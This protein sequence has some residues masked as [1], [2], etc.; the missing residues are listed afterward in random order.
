MFIT[1]II[2]VAEHGLV[3]IMMQQMQKEHKTTMSCSGSCVAPVTR[4]DSATAAANFI[5]L[6]SYMPCTRSCS[7]VTDL[8]FLL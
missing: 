7:N 6:S 8:S 1:K 3:K 5:F 2:P 4:S